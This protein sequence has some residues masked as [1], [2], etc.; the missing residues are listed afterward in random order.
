MGVVEFRVLS[1]AS[2]SGALARLDS[3]AA[4]R[5]GPVTEIGGFRFVR[6]QEA[7]RTLLLRRVSR[8][9]ARPLPLL[10]IGV[11]AVAVLAR[12]SSEPHAAMSHDVEH[13]A[14]FA[15]A[16][17]SMASDADVD[18]RARVELAALVETTSA[19]GSSPI[20]TSALSPS[21]SAPARAMLAKPAHLG[22]LP[23]RLETLADAPPRLVR[24]AAA[25]PDDELV[26]MLPM[27]EIVT[28][29]PPDD[30]ATEPSSEPGPEAEPGSDAEPDRAIP[31]ARAA[32]NSR[33]RKARS[34]SS[35][36]SASKKIQ[37]APRWA[38]QMFDN[39]WQSSAFSYV[40]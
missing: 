6:A 19:A 29:S 15:Y 31:K 3:F 18:D 4:L 16:R 25:A 20:T 17:P 24:L 2:A 34:R 37:R 28:R 33:P 40:R 13:P 22:V 26:P 35:S 38:R 9:L 11:L 23:P 8:R 30:P 10:F 39:P 32:R 1:A 5:V 21:A 14:R 36:S 12:P 7:R 27:V